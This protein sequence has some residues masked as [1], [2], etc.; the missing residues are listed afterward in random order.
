MKLS[1]NN[2]L[3]CSVSSLLIVAR[4]PITSCLEVHEVA[5]TVFTKLTDVKRV[6]VVFFFF[7]QRP[8]YRPEQGNKC[9]PLPNAL[10]ATNALRGTQ[11]VS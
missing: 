4:E 5:L 1:R 8:N 2:S 10:D 3:A 11:G 9:R 6:S 7:L